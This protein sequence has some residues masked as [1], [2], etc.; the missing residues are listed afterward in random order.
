MAH[1][2]YLAKK[3]NNSTNVLFWMDDNDFRIKE[4]NP[5]YTFVTKALKVGGTHQPCPK[6]GAP[7]DLYRGQ[8][9]KHYVRYSEDFSIREVNSEEM[10]KLM[11]P[12]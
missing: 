3:Y 11:Y 9:G 10:M 1:A 6:N 8:N 4:A 5:N 2:I 7:I 12:A